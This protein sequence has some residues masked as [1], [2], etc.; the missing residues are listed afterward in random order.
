MTLFKNVVFLR[1]ATT[2]ALLV[3][4]LLAVVYYNVGLGLRQ[5]TMFLPGLLC[6]FVAARLMTQ[7]RA[8]R[9]V[10]ASAV[11]GYAE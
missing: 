9:P 5:R 3:M 1:Y 10:E 2:F 6:L 7:F 8:Q 4:I 11:P